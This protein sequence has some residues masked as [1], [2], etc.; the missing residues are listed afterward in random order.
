VRNCGGGEKKDFV[1]PAVVLG[2]REVPLR[3]AEL[4][5]KKK[6]VS[7]TLDHAETRFRF[8]KYLENLLSLYAEWYLK[9]LA[10]GARCPVLKRGV[11]ARKSFEVG[12]G[13]SFRMLEKYGPLK[14]N[15]HIKG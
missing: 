14:K 6:L 15:I 8:E 13:S 4:Q 7:F 11:A 1:N 5:E 3:M 2:G 10:Q 9:G 12:G